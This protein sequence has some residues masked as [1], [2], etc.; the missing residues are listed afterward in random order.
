MAQIKKNDLMSL[1]RSVGKITESSKKELNINILTD[2]Q[3]QVVNFGNYI[4]KF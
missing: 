3:Y 2:Y 4:E 1:I